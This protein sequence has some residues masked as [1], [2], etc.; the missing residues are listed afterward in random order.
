MKPHPIKPIQ[1]S[2]QNKQVRTQLQH[3]FALQ[4]A[5][6]FG[7]MIM[8]L[9]VLLA[10]NASTVYNLIVGN[11]AYTSYDLNEL[12]AERFPLA[13]QLLSAP[14]AGKLT[15]LLF[16]ALIG[17]V[18]YMI[19][20]LIRNYSLRI[21]E[22]IDASHFVSSNNT[23]KGYLESSIAHHVFFACTIFFSLAYLVLSI[24]RFIPYSATL[25]NRV[26]ADL[27]NPINYFLALLAICLTSVTLY[28]LVILWRLLRNSWRIYFT[29]TE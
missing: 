5:E 22:D 25:F 12:L 10:A 21:F 6:F 7:L 29:A 2:E 19:V 28:I 27:T 17:S 4:P 1:S 15:Q 14:F 23:K 26:L 13:D 8:S 9:L 18:V 11:A 24:Y 16:W 20:W 3:F